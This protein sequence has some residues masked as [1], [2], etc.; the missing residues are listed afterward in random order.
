MEYSCFFQFCLE[1][2][3]VLKQD[4]LFRQENENLHKQKKRF[5]ACA[6]NKILIMLDRLRHERIKWRKDHPYGF[7][8]RPKGR[9]DGSFDLKEWEAAIPGMKSTIWEGGLL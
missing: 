8:A 6:C 5:P 4:N 2:S 3:R 9:E 1:R 7:W